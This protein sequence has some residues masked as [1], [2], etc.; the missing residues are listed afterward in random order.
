MTTPLMVKPLFVRWITLSIE[1]EDTVVHEFSCEVTQAGITSTGGDTVAVNTLCPQGSFSEAAERTWQLT[2]TGVQ[3]VTTLDSLIMFL[4][5][6]DGETA[7]FTYYPFVDRN[8]VSQGY[9]FTGTVTITP[10]DNVGNAASGSYATFTAVLPMT[11]K[12]TL[13]DSTGATVPNKGAAK[14]G[15][16]FPNEPTVTASDSTNAAKLAPLGYVAS[17]LT[18]WTTT[19]KILVNT[20]AF[21]WDGVAWAA[22]AAP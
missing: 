10:P 11:G 7:T 13:V 2:V 8:G 14:P 12:W 16:V 22:G 9:G 6:H 18:V 4:L 17:P 19:Q 3:D 20:Y 21:H 5:T 1:D 15:D